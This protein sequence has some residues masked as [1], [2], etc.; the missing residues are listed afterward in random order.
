MSQYEWP[1]ER[2]DKVPGQHYHLIQIPFDIE[3]DQETGLALKYQIFLQFEKPTVAYIGEAITN[4]AKTKL[5]QMQIELGNIL[6]PI[7]PLCSTRDER[8]WSGL[9][10]V[11]L[12]NPNIDRKQLLC[13]LRVLALELEGQLIV[14]KAAKGFDSPAL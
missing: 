2:D 5:Q 8:A 3:I 13:G 9:L 10:K 4:L 12:K 6:E 11:H 7:A 1:Q 14:A